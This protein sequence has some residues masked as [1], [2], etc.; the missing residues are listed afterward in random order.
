MT[1]Q[2]FAPPVVAAPPQWRRP[3]WLRLLDS[4]AESRQRRAE[5]EIAKYLRRQGG[6]HHELAELERRLLDR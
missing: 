4:I 5:Q 3:F 1:L 2:S 6:A